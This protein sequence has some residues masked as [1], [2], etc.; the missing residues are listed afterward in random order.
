[1]LS[2]PSTVLQGLGDIS[3]EG[4]C[5]DQATS[6]VRNDPKLE[7]DHKLKSVSSVPFFFFFGILLFRKHTRCMSGE[8]HV[9]ALG[10]SWKILPN[11]RQQNMK[12]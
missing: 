8:G 3:Q 2:L 11:S 6:V 7:L 12:D 1:M 4:I 9:T 10:N 5:K